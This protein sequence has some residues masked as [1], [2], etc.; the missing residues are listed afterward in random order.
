MPHEPAALTRLARLRADLTPDVDALRARA[1]EVRDLLDRYAV[2]EMPRAER[3]LLAA[4]LH[5][6]YTALETALERI[7]RLFDE[8]VPSGPAWHQE[9]LAQM[10]VEVPGIRGPVLATEVIA[11]LQELRRFRHFFR[12]AYVLDLDPQRLQEHAERLTAIHAQVIGGV[13]AFVEHL[14]AILSELSGDERA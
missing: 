11:D 4:N 14:G 5:G 13:D 1:D 7:A 6:Y 12:N 8:D 2:A 3:V 10:R 9:L